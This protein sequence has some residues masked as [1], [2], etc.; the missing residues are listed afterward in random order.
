MAT[1]KGNPM[2]KSKRIA[3][4]ADRKAAILERPRP[5][6]RVIVIGAGLAGRSA[7]HELTQAGHNVT[8][9]EATMRPGGRV[10][11]LR[12]PFSDGLHA[13]AGATR[14]PD[15]HHLTKPSMHPSLGCAGCIVNKSNNCTRSLNYRDRCNRIWK[16]LT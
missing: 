5:A 8:V 16:R 13:E 1:L 3:I 4:R 9:L 2:T 7:A 14:I 6:Q 15:A 11:T 10:R 12:E